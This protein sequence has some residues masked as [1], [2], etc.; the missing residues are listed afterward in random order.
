MN[1]LEGKFIKGELFDKSP[2]TYHISIIKHSCGHVLDTD[3]LLFNFGA[4]RFSQ[5]KLFFCF[6]TSQKCHR[7]RQTV[8]VKIG[9]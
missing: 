2:H 3:K 8:K 4:L 9:P 7:K 5:K 1:S 6:I